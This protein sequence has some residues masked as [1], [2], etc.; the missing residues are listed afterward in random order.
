LPPVKKH[1]L[2]ADNQELT[3]FGITAL[4]QTKGSY[5]VEQ[6]SD[7]ETLFQKM[8]IND[9]ILII[10]YQQ[11]KGFTAQD[12]IAIKKEMPKLITLVVTND[13]EKSTILS[14]LASGVNGFL[15]KDCQGDEIV[16]AVSSVQQG[17]K[18]FC[19]KVF[20]IV[21]QEQSAKLAENCLPTTLSSREIEIIKLVVAGKSTMAI[22]KQLH[23]SPHTVSTHR[24]NII[25]K[26]GIRSPVELV[27][28]AFELGLV[29]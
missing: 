21:M 28:Y 14:V 12:L 15:F 18:F 23:L 13:H 9:P 5:E 26:L 16:R 1:V 4:L 8:N 6:A 19:N 29:R 17:E 20:E 7:K 22:A 10:D 2:L 25:K 24:K 3:A 11:V 27:T